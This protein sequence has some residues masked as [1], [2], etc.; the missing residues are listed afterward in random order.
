[1]T[2]SGTPRK[3]NPLWVFLPIYFLDNTPRRYI[4][5]TDTTHDDEELYI[6]NPRK[7]SIRKYYVITGLLWQLDYSNP[8]KGKIRTAIPTPAGIHPQI[9]SD[10]TPERV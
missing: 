9:L 7:A 4:Y 6:I 5:D 8:Q 10:P 2:S 3:Q 1:M